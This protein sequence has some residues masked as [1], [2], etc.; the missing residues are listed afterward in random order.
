MGL[1]ALLE[2]QLGHGPKFQKL[3]IHSLSSPGG[4][5]GWYLGYFSSTGSGFRD[6]GPFLK[7][8]YFGMKLG[9]WPKF[10]KLH[11]YPLCSPG[12]RN[13]G[14][15][16]S[17]GSGFQDTGPFSK[18]PYI[19]VRNLASGQSSRSCTYTLFLPQR[20]EIELNSLYAQWFPRYRLIFK[21]AIFG[22]E[23]WP[24]AKVPEL[25]HILSFYPTGSKLS[26]FSLY[27][28]RFLRYRL[29]SKIAIKLGHETWPLAFVHILFL[30]HR[31][32]IGLIFTLLAGVSNFMGRFSKLPYL[33][34]KLGHWPI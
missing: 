34:M 4:G 9:K 31:V 11:I 18:L 14:Y 29:F 6:M 22:H 30:P 1:D 3:H 17:T 21:I 33:S 5:V 32:E 12:G 23:T 13:W 20:V 19:W 16:C 8:P 27:K 25:A 15:F 26:L 7:L 28:Q 24:L 2:N 10:Q